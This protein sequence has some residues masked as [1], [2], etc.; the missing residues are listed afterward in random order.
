M[1]E[2]KGDLW[3]YWKKSRTYI[4]I[5]TNGF[6]KKNGEAVMGRGCALQATKHIPRVKKRLGWRITNFGNKL[7]VFRKDRF[8]TF[9]TKHNWWEPS[10]LFLIKKS[11][12]ELDHIAKRNPRFRFILP[13]PGCRNG[14]LDWKDVRPLLTFMEDNI[15]VITNEAER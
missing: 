10:D 5:T 2:I 3:D 13:R 15:Y 4:C 6:T 7:H 14:R 11:A 12:T 8:I 1:K 9:P